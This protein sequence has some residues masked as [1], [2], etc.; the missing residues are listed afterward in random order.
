MP[1]VSSTAA[2]WVALDSSTQASLPGA[3]ASC[4]SSTETR[5]G[6]ISLLSDSAQE[7]DF[8][9][10][11]RDPALTA[12]SVAPSEQGRSGLWIQ[13]CSLRCCSQHGFAFLQHSCITSHGASH[14]WR[15]VPLAGLSTPICFVRKTTVRASFDPVVAIPPSAQGCMGKVGVHQGRS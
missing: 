14:C 10:R 7:Y 8:W 4:A 2:T 6:L 15:T 12:A 3:A 11:H 5:A 13:A 1:V 9:C